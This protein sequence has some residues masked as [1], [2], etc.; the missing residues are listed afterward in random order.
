TTP[1]PGSTTVRPQPAEPTTATGQPTGATAPVPGT[2]TIAGKHKHHKGL[3]NTDAQTKTAPESGPVTTGVEP[4]TCDA[5]GD[6]VVDPGAPASCSSGGSVSTGV[7]QGDVSPV[8][9]AAPKK[10]LSAHKKK[11][12]QRRARSR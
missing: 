4:A 7:Q 1:P 8:A 2:K 11:I 10:H 9:Y 12:R 3:A 6:G 5:D